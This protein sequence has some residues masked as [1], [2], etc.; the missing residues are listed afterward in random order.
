MNIKNSLLVIGV[1]GAASL[2]YLYS[3]HDKQ[4]VNEK[5]Y[6]TVSIDED[7]FDDNPLPIEATNLQN[8]LKIDIDTNTNSNKLDNKQ[9]SAE[10]VTHEQL[11]TAISDVNGLSSEAALSLIRKKDFYDIV[12]S[13]EKLNGESF[14][15][16]SQ[17]RKNIEQQIQDNNFDM[18]LYTFNCNDTV[19]AA[20]VYY[21]NENEL[22][23]FLDSP[24][25]SEEQPAAIITQ[26]V[27][28]DGNKEF[29]IILNY[30]TSS[31]IVN[32]GS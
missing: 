21:S 25:A 12:E 27:V 29:R 32:T 6:T 26:P 17:F 30:K 19:C 2:I 9:L 28:V 13:L 31:I 15:I 23:K 10:E 5:Q 14:D 16:Q 1:I 18:Y 24:F 20:S 7:K 3:N 11:I 8:N 4:P 22:D